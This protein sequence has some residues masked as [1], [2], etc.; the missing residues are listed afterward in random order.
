MSTIRITPENNEL[1]QLKSMRKDDYSPAT[2]LAEFID[3]S[4][5]ARRKGQSMVRVDI[6][7]YQDTHTQQFI[8]SVQDNACGVEVSL[9]GKVLGKGNSIGGGVNNEHGM[10][11]KQAAI[12]GDTYLRSI[13]TRTQNASTASK[14]E[15]SRAEDLIA[16][17]DVKN[18]FRLKS[19]GTRLEIVLPSNHLLL[20]EGEYYNALSQLQLIY[21]KVLDEKVHITAKNDVLGLPMQTLQAD[22]MVKHLHNPITNDSSWIVE[23][24]FTGTG[25]RPWHASVRIGFISDVSFKPLLASPATV[26]TDNTRHGRGIEQ[27]GISIF[28]GDR[29]IEQQKPWK[30][31]SATNVFGS[32][33]VGHGASNGLVIEID[34]DNNF[35]TTRTKNG[36]SEQTELTELRE[37]LVAYLGR[38]QPD[39]ADDQP[40][41]DIKPLY[42]YLQDWNNKSKFKFNPAEDIPWH[43]KQVKFQM[44]WK[45]L[46]NFGKWSLS[47]HGTKIL[48]VH[49]NGA[50]A[51]VPRCDIPDMGA[52]CEHIDK[53]TKGKGTL[54]IFVTNDTSQLNFVHCDPKYQP[55]VVTARQ[56]TKEIAQGI[57]SMNPKTQ[58]LYNA[59]VGAAGI[60]RAGVKLSKSLQ[61]ENLDPVPDGIGP[62]V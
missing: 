43:H 41:A 39:V 15:F 29:Q 7:V 49:K 34:V 47:Q 57:P 42:K 32:G 4:N 59:S 35:P 31:G 16:T 20:Q 52:L 13:E 14:V 19:P 53:K 6:N 8:L 26:S 27:Q 9:L 40:A 17:F 33:T 1:A 22:S 48:V 28:K 24:T 12:A 10:G 55:S 18:S 45:N 3:N 38:I 58:A 51:K 50:D 21:Q 54:P 5:S 2:V 56:A 61:K 62:S 46:G 23:K 25:I 60:A 36:I 44:D 11:L 30:L 37:Q